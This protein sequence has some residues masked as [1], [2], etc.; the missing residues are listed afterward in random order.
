MER[1]PTLLKKLQKQFDENAQVKEMLQTVQLLQAELI[2]HLDNNPRSSN[3][4]IAVVMPVSFI[5]DALQTTANI[6]P[7]EEK[8][9]EVLQVNQKEIEEELEQIKKHAESVNS[10]SSHSRPSFLFDFALA[11]D[12]DTLNNST[13]PALNIKAHTSANLLPLK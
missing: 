10:R 7:A 1:V 3:Q 13:N 4:K 6:N 8:V 2:Q 5:V 9:V 12:L 11:L